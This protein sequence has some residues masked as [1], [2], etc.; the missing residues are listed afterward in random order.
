ML[1]GSTSSRGWKKAELSSFAPC[2]NEF[3]KSELAACVKPYRVTITTSATEVTAAT[4]RSVRKLKWRPTKHSRTAKT[5]NV[6]HTTQMP[7]RFTLPL[8][9]NPSTWVHPAAADLSRLNIAQQL[10]IVGA[11]NLG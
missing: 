1:P 11:A 2:R 8:P 7:Q 6:P 10:N 9:F 3:A 4:N 5:A